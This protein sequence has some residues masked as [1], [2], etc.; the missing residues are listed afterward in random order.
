MLRF[1]SR[2]F[3]TT[4]PKKNHG[5]LTVSDKRIVRFVPQLI[6]LTWNFRWHSTIR[7]K[8]PKQHTARRSQKKDGQKIPLNK[9]QLNV[10][11]VKYRAD[12]IGGRHLA[13]GERCCSEDLMGLPQCLSRTEFST[14][15]VCSHG[16]FVSTPTASAPPMKS[17]L[18]SAARGEDGV[19]RAASVDVVVGASGVD[20]DGAH[21]LV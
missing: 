5:S 14:V 10:W 17:L 11:L 6:V 16:R 8:N 13:S 3:H 19:V 21:C 4:F 20:V 2:K 1:H 12:L 18:L 9:D 7:P 15:F